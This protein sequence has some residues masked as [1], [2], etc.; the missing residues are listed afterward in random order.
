MKIQSNYRPII[1]DGGEIGYLQLVKDSRLLFPEIEYLLDE[2]YW[3]QGIMSEELPKYLDYLR[4]ENIT[5]LHALVEVK[6]KY[7]QRLLTKYFAKTK[8]I[9]DIVHYMTDLTMDIKYVKL[10][11]KL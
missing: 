1:R 5:R 9:D 4:S 2:N 8:V 10:I 11:E 3:N 7:S 6:N